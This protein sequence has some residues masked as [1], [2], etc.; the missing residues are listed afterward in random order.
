MHP[1]LLQIT[2]GKKEKKTNEK[3]CVS[4]SCM[5]VLELEKDILNQNC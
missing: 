5:S 2:L 3:K 1:P 4:I